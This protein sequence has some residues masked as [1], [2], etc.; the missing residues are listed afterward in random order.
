[1]NVHFIGI[2]GIGLSGLARFLKYRGYLVSGSDMTATQITK[3]LSLDG[4]NI[5]TPH[6]KN[7]IKGQDLIIY[8]AAILDDNIEIIEAKKQNLLILTRKEAL[9]I[10]LSK[11]Q[12][13]CICAAHGKS[14]TTAILSAILQSSTII[15]AISKEFNSNFR[16]IN[17]ILAFE[18]DESDESFVFSNPYCSIVLNTELE[19]MEY[20][21][22]DEKLFYD[23][24]KK[25]LDI[26]EIRIINAEDDF[27]K[28]YKGDSIKLYPS[29]DIKNIKYYLK[30]DE[31][32]TKFDLKDIGEFNVWGFGEHI[33]IDASCAILAG[34]ETLNVKEIKHN[35]LK[36]KGIKKRFDIIQKNKN[37]IVIDDY[38]HHPTEIKATLKSVE[39]YKK[40]K[41]INNI[42]V[43][44]QPHKYSRTIDNLETFKKCFDG[45]SELIILP[46]WSVTE[47]IE[48]INFEKEFAHYNL[49]LCDKLNSKKGVIE[50]IKNDI[51]I[52]I[53]NQ[54]IIVGVGAGDITYQIRVDKK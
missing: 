34:L 52:K 27:L 45:C 5:T 32:Y 18:A 6:N 13:Y 49:V 38:A 19:H 7:A 30:N 43:I 10:I 1:M 2:G 11:T 3:Q 12:N 17:N 23:A 36:Y 54:G 44:W 22:Y 26:A 9:S 47:K 28:N 41:D 14:T 4:I 21:N 53:L 15:G 39:L 8:S 33:A 37:F 29:K 35:L 42:I 24:Y 20:Y 16:Y 50:L 48:Y 40:Y 51:V 46:V 25:F 31:P